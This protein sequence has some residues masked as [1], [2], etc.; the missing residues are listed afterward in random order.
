MVWLQK[1]NAS[2]SKLRDQRATFEQAECTFQPV[3]HEFV[4]EELLP[5]EL[6]AEASEP[7]CRLVFDGK[8]YD[9]A[10]EKGFPLFFDQLATQRKQRSIFKRF[11]DFSQ[12]AG[13]PL[14]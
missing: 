1:K 9:L 11:R 12:L 5:L 2:L 10:R 7:E 4:R 8:T 13:Q 3:T 6:L 14:N